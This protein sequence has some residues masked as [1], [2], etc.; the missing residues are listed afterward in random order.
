MTPL[1][2]PGASGADRAAMRPSLLMRP[3]RCLAALS[4]A[5]GRPS[6]PRLVAEGPAEV[7]EAHGEGAA[8]RRGDR[9]AARRQPVWREV[10]A[11]L[12]ADALQQG[13]V[14][15]AQPEGPGIAHQ[16]Q[17][18]MP[19]DGRGDAARHRFRQRRT[20]GAFEEGDDA[21]GVDARRR[22]VPERVPRQPVVVE[23]ARA[24]LQ[25]RETAQRI[26]HPASA[27]GPGGEEEFA[28][29]LHYQ[30]RRERAHRPPSSAIQLPRAVLRA[31]ISTN[32][33]SRAK[34]LVR[35]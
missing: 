29:V 3:Q 1:L 15:G 16:A 17:L 11:Q 9:Q 6:V 34:T 25:D 30:G 27:G 22:R 33:A 5:R 24:L 8:P 10:V 21:R 35:T 31:S 26:G 12:R 14:V 18:P 7:A 32:R 2:P 20:R 28:V 13:F 23:G 4:I 19:R